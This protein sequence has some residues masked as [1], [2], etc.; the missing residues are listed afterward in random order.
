MTPR[1]AIAPDPES[2]R[3]RALDRANTVR[4]A[5]AGLKH[6]VNAGTT[7]AAAV[8]LDPPEEAVTMT[9][10]ELLA[11]QR[12]W[13]DQRVGRFLAALGLSE[14]KTVGSLTERQRRLLAD[15]LGCPLITP[16]PCFPPPHAT[17]P[18]STAKAA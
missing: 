7:T 4:L 2:Q 17:Q 11:S 5:R 8:I 6:R 15:A 12:R 14:G 16:R 18:R 3:M 13:G 9:L 10:G 1:V